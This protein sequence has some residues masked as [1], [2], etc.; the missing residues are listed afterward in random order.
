MNKIKILPI[1]FF[2]ALAF[3][4]GCDS[5][6]NLDGMKANQQATVDS[7]VQS[8][9][10]DL[11]AEL[12]EECDKQVADAVSV[13]V[14]E[15]IAA[16]AGIGA[17]KTTKPKPKPPKTTKPKPPTTKPTTPP[18]TTTPSTT[19]QDGRGGASKQGETG[20]QIDRGGAS[21]KG[22]TGGQQGRGGAKRVGDGK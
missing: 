9:L 4:V 13:R 3:M 5:A 1:L 19:T 14:E 6:A 2:S 7:L 8:H 20:S 10:T 12:L 17:G 16:A 22:E 11:R 15:M 18:K 21:K